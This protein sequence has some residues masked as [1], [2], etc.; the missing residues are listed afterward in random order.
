[1]EGYGVRQHQRER[2]VLALREY[3]DAQFRAELLADVR[4][5]VVPALVARVVARRNLRRGGWLVA[6]ELGDEGGEWFAGR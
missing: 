2:L 6:I 5:G 3:V 1:M 4:H